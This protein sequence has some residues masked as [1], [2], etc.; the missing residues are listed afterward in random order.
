MNHALRQAMAKAKITEQQLAEKC[1]VDV[2]TVNR[3]LTN[4]TRVPHARHRWEVCASL[5]AEEAVLWPSAV[6]L[7]LKTGPDREV[8]QVFP[9][10]SAAPASL[11]R[12]LMTN[13]KSE[14]TNAG[15]TNYFLWLEHAN[16]GSL[17]RRKAAN[18]CTVRFLI[19]DPD[20]DVT[21]AREEE[22]SVP[23][24]LSTR[25]AVTLAELHKLRDVSSIAGR[26]TNGHVNLSVFRFDDDMIVTPILARRVGHDSPMFHLRR[27]Q[28]DGMFDR[29][30]EHVE[31]L[32]SRGRDIWED[33]N[34]GA[35]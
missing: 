14:L 35:P 7:T 33:A 31:E 11:W 17:L 23:L 15:Y 30:S 29:F 12:S 4:P 16:L 3:W 26:F 21:R 28:E 2:K 25:I 32:W 6:R 9:Y 8:V 5:G 24:T 10:R 34:H 1:G 27:E 20:D 18:G 19:G 13:A 22:E